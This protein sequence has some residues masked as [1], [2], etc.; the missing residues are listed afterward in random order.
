[1]NKD[2][3]VNKYTGKPLDQSYLE[4]NLREHLQKAIK[5]YIEGEKKNVGHID[6]LWG[7]LYGSIN[8][9][10]WAGIITEEQANYL[11][12]KYLF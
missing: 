11:R 12:K 3:E 8:A 2:G 7:E 9:D 1:M 5:E 4:L 10:Y 6:L